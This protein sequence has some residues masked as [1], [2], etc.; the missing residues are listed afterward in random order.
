M[1]TTK[2]N[3]ATR[4]VSWD[5]SS[6]Q[7]S[8]EQFQLWFVCPNCET[9]NEKPFSPV[10]LQSFGSVEAYYCHVCNQEFELKV[11][12]KTKSRRAP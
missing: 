12:F 11:T 5:V 8:H 7:N 6:C 1:T 9:H 2:R 3:G 10:F 4:T